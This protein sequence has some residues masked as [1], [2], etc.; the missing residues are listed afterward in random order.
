MTGVERDLGR[1]GVTA[2]VLRVPHHH[3]HAAS[4]RLALP[5]GEAA[6]LTADGM[7]EWTTAASWR[8]TPHELVRLAHAAYPHSPGKAYSAV[9]AWLGFRP[10]SEE[11]K[12]MGLAAYGDPESPEAAFARALLRPDERRILRVALGRFSFPTGSPRLYGRLFL[13]TLGPARAP[14]E[15]LRPADAS[16]ARGL[17]D[18]VEEVFGRAAERLLERT[19]AT[20][21][22][23]AGGLFLNC[24][25]NGAIARR[26]RAR[27]SPS[28]AGDAGAAWG[29][30]AVA[31]ARAA[32]TPAAP[33][34]TLRL[35]HRIGAFEAQAAVQGRGAVRHADEDALAHAVAR[36]LAEG[37]IVGVARGAA[38]F[39]PRALGG[40][41]VL[42][43]P[44][45]TQLRDEVNRRKGREAWRPLAPVVREGETRWFEDLA[46]SPWMIRTFRAT[47]EARARLPGI[48][49]ADGTARVQT[50]A[51]SGD[52]FLV[53]LLRHL[54]A[55]GEPPAV[56]NTSLNRPGEPIANTALEALAAA[57]AMGLD[58]LAVDL[59]LLDLPPRSRPPQG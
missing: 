56:I 39:G 15:P 33:L 22:G 21:L 40:R 53:A 52:P 29:A 57:E 37:C 58:A 12:T 23:L 32:G 50:V 8:V 28:V 1:I 46:D 34:T 7:G 42:A 9:T 59:W 54:E 30:A 35:G 51:R 43:S 26:V 13:E 49:H 5:D 14:G 2:P 18:A 48:V 19:G 20:H 45:R 25:L 38:E 44:R 3:A 17:Q 41:S 6:V 47:A 4:A 36:R 10:E 11:G 55:L 27:V 31:H 24:A 16:V